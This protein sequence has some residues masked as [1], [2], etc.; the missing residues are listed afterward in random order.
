MAFVG[1]PAVI[2][3]MTTPR[4]MSPGTS[5]VS[6]PTENASSSSAANGAKAS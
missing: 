2:N 6:V 5:R 1:S 4:V 3:A